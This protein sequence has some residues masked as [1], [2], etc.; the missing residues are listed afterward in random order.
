MNAVAVVV[1]AVTVLVF[2]YVRS[3]NR[4]V[5]DR[6]VL[7]DA[8]AALITEL[9]RRHELVGQ[10]AAAVTASPIEERRLID[11]LLAKLRV[12][13]E[14]GPDAEARRDPED[15]LAQAA[16]A[17]VGL[18]RQYPEL[19]RQRSFNDVR[20]ELAVNDDRVRDAV[21]YHDERAADLGRR[22]RGFPS[23]LVAR[24]HGFAPPAPFA[25]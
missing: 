19:D 13:S 21:R 11:D 5:N 15:E 22:M 9:D 14:A 20:R 10:L 18:R 3:F 17:V 6:E 8:W 25:E 24:V 7:D 1:V 23:S 16:A 4:L 12:A 2:A